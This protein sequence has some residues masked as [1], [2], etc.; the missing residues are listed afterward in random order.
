MSGPI[1][2][3]PTDRLLCVGTTGS[4]KT[5][6]LR[7]L[8]QTRPYRIVLDTKQDP[9]DRWL[10]Q[11]VGTLDRLTKVWNKGAI[12]YQPD[13]D[14]IQPRQLEAFFAFVYEVAQDIL[15]VVDEAQTD[16]ILNSVRYS[17]HADLLLR[18]GRGRRVPLWMGSQRPMYLKNE[19][20]SESEH[21]FT[22]EL[23]LLNDR[24]KMAGV[25]GPRVL[26]L[27]THDNEPHKPFSAWYTHKGV[28]RYMYPKGWNNGPA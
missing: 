3:K 19:A 7:S 12:L 11:K 21:I 17:R 23:R 16:G 28:T 4:G 2:I 1:R 5:T 24:R 22:F 9:D 18:Q 8:A 13:S 27:P 26:Q 25:C 15:I 20:I 14:N 6:L 10:G